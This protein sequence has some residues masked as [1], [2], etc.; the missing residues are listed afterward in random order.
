MKN[1]L[2]R[3]FYMKMSV[4]FMADFQASFAPKENSEFTEGN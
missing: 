1:F 2:V 4:S 3:Q